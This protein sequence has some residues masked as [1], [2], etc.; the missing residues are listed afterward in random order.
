M[1][2]YRNGIANGSVP[3]CLVN[4]EAS[5]KER[6]VLDPK[7]RKCLEDAIKIAGDASS[8]KNLQE[9]ALDAV[10]RQLGSDRKDIDIKLDVIS[11]AVA[12]EHCGNR[13]GA[14][15]ILTGLCKDSKLHEKTIASLFSVG[16]E[17]GGR[18][19]MDSDYAKHIK[20]IG[21]LLA[22][23]KDH[24]AFKDRSGRV[25]L[26]VDEGA[27]V[28][29]INYDN[30][31]KLTCAE[32]MYGKKIVRLADGNYTFGERDATGEKNRFYA[33]RDVSTTEKGSICLRDR[34]GWTLLRAVS[35]A[36]YDKT[37]SLT[38]SRAERE[39][40]CEGMGLD[41]FDREVSDRPDR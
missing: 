40:K 5:R 32:T 18:N 12:D 21:R 27:G 37:G 16:D 38:Y 25:R 4:Q 8:T 29:I 7:A 36:R 2:N 17:L 24:C 31:G 13:I 41:R 34:N 3:S 20:D 33:A 23:Q 15:V 30:K 35:S 39:G 22:P 28:G 19:G 6:I 14:K 1:G 11:R 26:H 9:R 10:R